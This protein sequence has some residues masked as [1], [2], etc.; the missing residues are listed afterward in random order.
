MSA[1]L[2]S[3]ALGR[4]TLARQLLLF[5]ADL[6]AAGAVDALL[7]LQAQVPAVPYLAL[8]S[9]LQGFAPQE[10]ADHLRNRTMVRAPLM[11][12]TLHLV[13]AGDARTLRPLLQ[14]V[15][16][17][18]FAGTAWSKQLAG[19][20]LQDVLASGRA[21]LE[22]A[23][24]TRAAVAPLLAERHPGAD[25]EALAMAATYLLPV[26]QVTPRGVWGESGPAAF[27]TMESWLGAAPPSTA[28]PD[29]LVLRFLR[30]YGPATVKD[31]Q[32][33]SGLTHLHEVAD[34]LGPRLRRFRTDG[35][36]ELFDVPE[37]LLPRPDTPAP[38]RFLPEY[39]NAILAYADRSRVIGPGEHVPL[40]GGPG[41]LV[42]T[43]LIDGRV[44]AMWALRRNKGSAV[45]LIRP[46]EPL[47][48][49]EMDDVLREGRGLLELSASGVEH[50]IHILP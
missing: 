15:L 20:G 40:L 18:T 17:R 3:R 24:R 14:P 12:A 47:P 2:T 35:G 13:S 30:G 32:C 4:A 44:S 27:T 36:A 37:G 10:L 43:L 42:G 41:G 34:R 16:A 9:R 8:W 1:A 25:A 45:L 23:P 50:D 49:R 29:D 22:Q 11:R 26:V 31:I 48:R 5:R 21:L 33:W 6:S 46:S 7:G 28:S 19:H 39:D 38:P